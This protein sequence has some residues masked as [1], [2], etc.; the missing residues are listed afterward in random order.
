MISRT[1][2]P[3]SRKYSAMAVAR[4]AP[5][6]R[7]S[8]VLS[9]GAA[10]TTERPPTLLAQDALDEFLHFATALADQADDDDVGL[11]VAGHHAQQHALAH[12]GAGEQADALAAT[13]GQQRIDGAHADIQRA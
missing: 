13:N 7:I 9:A 3:W 11:G 1:F 12:A 2:W 5:C 6:R 8:G 10:T 4:H